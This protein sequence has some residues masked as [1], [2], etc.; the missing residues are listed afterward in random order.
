MRDLIIAGAGPAGSAAALEAAKHGLDVLLLDKDPFPRHKPCGGALSSQTLRQLDRN[1][2]PGLAK[3]FFTGGRLRFADNGRLDRSIGQQAGALV[4]RSEFDAW[5]AQCAAEAGAEFRHGERVLSLE[6]DLRGVTVR[7]AKTTERARIA[8]VAEGATGRLKQFVRPPD[9]PDDLVFCACADVPADQGAAR[10]GEP[11][12][13][14]F[15]VAPI[16]YGWAFP[17]EADASVGLGELGRNRKR[18]KNDFN[19]FLRLN[20]IPQPETV[21]GHVIPM[22]GTPRKIGKGRVLLAGDAGGFADALL[23]EG[24]CHAVRTGQ[25]AAHACAEH[26][27]RG[28]DLNVAATHTNLCEPVR[29]ELQHALNLVNALRYAPT[30]LFRT[31][32]THPPTLDEYIR[33]LA[34][35]RT[36]KQFNTKLKHDLPQHIL[37]AVLGK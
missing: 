2:P 31:M 29:I 3:R 5:M 25:A 21:Q 28:E 10:A 32:L 24:I 34:G 4:L 36:Y 23:G 15:G 20:N 35:H 11:L 30:P 9:P 17:R 27:P 13:L 12:L 26:L 16:L 6:E 33:I 19:R 18:L 37:R 8:L 1:L 7:T 14:H 22:G